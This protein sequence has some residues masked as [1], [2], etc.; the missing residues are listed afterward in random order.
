MKTPT[1]EVEVVEVAEEEEGEEE[2]E[3]EGVELSQE[4]V[5]ERPWLPL[6]LPSH[7]ERAPLSRRN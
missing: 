1:E 7:P 5:E 4:G 3:E 2:E 6:P